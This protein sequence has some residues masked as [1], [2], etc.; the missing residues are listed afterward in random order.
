MRSRSFCF[1]INN[2]TDFEN[3]NINDQ[4][5]LDENSVTWIIFALEEGESGTPHYQGYVQ[6]KHARTIKGVSR[7]E[8]F[9]R[10][11]L[12]IARG[13]MQSNY[14]Y[15][16]K[17]PIELYEFGTRPKQGQRNDL[18]SLVEY[19]TSTDNVSYDDLTLMFPFIVAKYPRYCRDLINV[20]YKDK[21][22]Q[23]YEK[24]KEDPTQKKVIVLYGDPG[25]GKTRYVY[26]KYPIEDIYK[27]N[28]GDGT[29]NSL[30]FDDYNG[31]NILLIDDFYGNIKY[32]YMLRL[33]D[34]YPLRLQT[35]GSFVNCNFKKIYM[36]S[37]VHPDEWYPN[38]DTTA[39][40]RR[41]T[42]IKKK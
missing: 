35:K 1:T 42:K 32:S 41:I 27:V 15:V 31:E 5:F 14:E 4:Y 11:H 39:L 17:D 22:R 23:M 19:V 3:D 9:S 33:L 36:T 28:I 18:I 8:F 6:F 25:S 29:K 13:S 2:P 38:I 7:M 40:K 30:W 16:T 20:R 12:E 10:A 37:N 26:D 24:F 21:S 34:I